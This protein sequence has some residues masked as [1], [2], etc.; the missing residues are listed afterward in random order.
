MILTRAG[1]VYLTLQAHTLCSAILVS[2]SS[3]LMDLAVCSCQND[4][5][6]AHRSDVAQQLEA[7]LLLC[8]AIAVFRW[9]CAR[10]EDTGA[11]L[12]HTR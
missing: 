4:H 3:R 8:C 6:F 5:F 10:A 9:A 1:P 12:K 2:V 7:Q 11:A